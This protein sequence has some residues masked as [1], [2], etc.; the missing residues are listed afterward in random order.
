MR[1]LPASPLVLALVVAAAGCSGAPVGPAESDT[2]DLIISRIV[3]IDHT[4]AGASVNHDFTRSFTES[5]QRG[6]LTV[7]PTVTPHLHLDLTHPRVQGTVVIGKNQ[8][9]GFETILDAGLS[10][11]AHYGAEL[12]V[13]FS[14]KTNGDVG[15]IKELIA[16]EWKNTVAGGKPLALADHLLESDIPVTDKLHIKAHFDV[17]AACAFDVDGAVDASFSVGV[18]GDLAASAEYKKEGFEDPNTSARKKHF[19]FSGGAPNFHLV[20]GPTFKFGAAQTHVK[21]RCSV[22]PTLVVTLEDKLGLKVVVEPYVALQTNAQFVYGKPIQWKIDAAP[23]V[24]VSA[25]TDLTLFG[26]E[27]FAPKE[28]DLFDQTLPELHVVSGG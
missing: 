1:L 15:L 4:F 2:Q 20:R 13:D 25:E 19:K 22:Q 16:K 3:S 11:T 14:I 23:G 26:R 9:I 28:F 8:R 27:L 18:A 10:A 12:D 17:T 5:I 7:T 24:A 21:G 6:G